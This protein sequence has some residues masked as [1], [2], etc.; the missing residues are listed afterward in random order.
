[1]Q[2]NAMQFVLYP[3]IYIY[4]Y[5]IS[6][7]NIQ[8]IYIL[9]QDDDKMIKN[10]YHNSMKKPNQNRGPAY[11]LYDRYDRYRYRSITL[12][13]NRRQYAYIPS[14]CLLYFHAAARRA[15]AA[16]AAMRS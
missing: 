13:R 5:A 14:T 4:I 11:F 12:H 10:G 9:E 6:H 2:C 7:A 16:H 8:L 3:Y 15:P 1:M